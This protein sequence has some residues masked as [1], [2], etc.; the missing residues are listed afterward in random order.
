MQGEAEELQAEMKAV[1]KKTQPPTPN[2][3][4][5]EQMA[6]KELRDDNTRMISTAEKG[7]LMVVMDR[8]EYI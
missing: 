6:L 7:V 8:E 4:R 3:T 5:E 1:L 2:I